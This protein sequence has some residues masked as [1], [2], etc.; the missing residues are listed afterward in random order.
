M[1]S[2]KKTATRGRP[3]SITLERITTAGI[4]IGLS[5]MTFVGV[6]AALGVSHMALYKHVSSIEV[7]KYMVAEEIFNR[8]RIPE[9]EENEE[10]KDYLLRLTISLRELIKANTGLS[11]YIL[12]RAVSTPV[13][14][15]KIAANHQM[16]AQFYNLPQDKVRWLVA[17]IAFHCIAVADTVY[18]IASK[19]P[20]AVTSRAVEEA[21]MEA[22]F[23]QSMYAL[24]IGALVLVKDKNNM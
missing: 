8:W 24:I 18:N 5:N 10:L 4:E 14:V 17:T 12:R 11:P 22:E 16:I 20:I 19:E 9:P 3:R 2:V 1:P 21:E 7:I 23:S 6:A 15:K 13:I